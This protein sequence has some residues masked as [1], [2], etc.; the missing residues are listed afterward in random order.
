MKP[1]TPQAIPNPSAG[2]EHASRKSSL[3]VSTKITLLSFSMV[4]LTVV[5]LTAIVFVQKS[6][7]APV[8]G[9][10][11]D[12]QAFAESSKIV[13]IIR[14]NCASAQTQSHRQLEHGLTV[15]RETLL[16]KGA[17]TFAG[18]SVAWEA[19]NQVNQQKV[20]VDLPKFCVGGEWIGQNA[21]WKARSPI[22]DEARHLTNLQVTLFQRMNDAGDMLRVATTLQR[23]DGSRA[24]GTFIPATNA[25]GQPNAIVASVLKGE[26]YLGRA[27]GMDTWYQAMYEPLW[28]AAHQ[29][30]IGMLFVGMDMTEATRAVR[31][32]IAKITVGKTGYVFVFGSKND[33]RGKYIVSQNGAADGKQMWETRDTNGE[34]VVQNIIKAGLA[35]RGDRAERV[36]YLWSDPGAARAREKFSAVTYFEPWDWVIGV[37]AYYD[38]Y[39]ESQD[40]ALSTLS[41]LLVWTAG[42]ALVL[43]AAAFI[44]SKRLALSVTRPLTVLMHTAQQIAR[45]DNNARAAVESDDEIGQL[46]E[47]F[48]SM[49][50]ARV[51]AKEE[52]DDYKKLQEGIQQLLRVT[53]DASDG[54]LTVRAPVTDG[55]LGNVSDAVNLMLEN[56]GELIK[57]VQESAK[58]V[59]NSA[60]EIQASSEQLA[61]GAN[62]QNQE[63]VNTSSA[64]Q[65]MAAN[66]ESVSSNAAAANEAAGRARKAAEEGTKAVQD[67]ISGMERIRENVQAGAKKIKRLGE[68]SMEISTIVN[69]INQI[70]A[71]TDMLALNAAIE[72]ARAGEHGRGFTVVAEEVRKLAERAAAATQE[73]EK[74]VASI[75]AETNESVTSMEQQTV[76]VEEGSQTVTTAGASLDRIRE[77]S[78]QSAELINEISLAAKQQVRGANGVVSAMQ[79]VSQIAQQAQ[80]GAG[81]TRR[82]TESLVTLANELLGRAVKFKV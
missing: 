16:A 81:Q 66:T 11:L 19:E 48:N 45:G 44:V 59:A 67:V 29:K 37:S 15:A 8:L 34:F 12:E 72:A 69:T 46:G 65:E 21:N 55:A 18:E 39:R 24:I 38:E 61:R 33:L 60:M 42:V 51:K 52:T 40:A 57:N 35:S 62:T 5:V 78:V 41:Q 47:A 10:Y 26:N 82:A 43:V 3:K 50:D 73:I 17:V 80:G 58:V 49:L 28:D 70:S 23:A 53:A 75:Q 76:Q 1:N 32:S 13:R 6:R 30:V 31:E 22:V 25:D 71:Q 54:D 27:M 63:I 7:L 36:N 20:R 64:V 4:A 77:A 74:L 2:A 14:D 9:R 79:T 56:V 68:R